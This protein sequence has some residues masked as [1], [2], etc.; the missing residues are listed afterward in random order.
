MGPCWLMEACVLE[1]VTENRVGT[2]SEGLQR[3]VNISS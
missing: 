3:L 1:T 2:Q